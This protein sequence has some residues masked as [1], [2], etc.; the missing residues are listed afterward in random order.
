MGIFDFVKDAGAMLFGG[1]AARAEAKQET[2]QAL[3]DTVNQMGLKIEDLSIEFNDEV[4]IIKGKTV[5]QA[6]REKIVLLVGN[7]KGVG[8]VDDQMTIETPAPESILY[9]VKSGDTLSKIAQVQYG[10]VG[11]YMVIF[12][13]NKPMLQDPDKI[14]PGQTLRI[15]KLD[16]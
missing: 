6:E 16:A 5:S 14:Y 7:T 13:A 11:K 15:P 2:E 1:K 4:A 9:T 10:S 8:R 12:D 3:V